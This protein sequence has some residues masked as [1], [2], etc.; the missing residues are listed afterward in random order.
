MPTNPEARPGKGR[1]AHW[2]VELE[3]GNRVFFSS[4]ERAAEFAQAYEELHGVRV[5]VLEVEE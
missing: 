5:A 2:I 1:T 4:P 3:D